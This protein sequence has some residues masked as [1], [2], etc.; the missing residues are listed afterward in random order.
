M[1][2]ASGKQKAKNVLRGGSNFSDLPRS[3]AMR[4]MRFQGHIRAPGKVIMPSTLNINFYA[5]VL[6]TLNEA[7]FPIQNLWAWTDKLGR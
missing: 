3:E 1:P 2:A 7:F 4:H 6:R 5:L